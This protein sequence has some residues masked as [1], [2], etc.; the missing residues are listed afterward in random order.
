[1]AW[2]IGLLG[3]SKIARGAVIAPAKASAD[4]EVVE[5]GT[6]Y[7]NSNVPSGPFPTI[8]SFTANATSVAKGTPA[9]EAGLHPGDVIVAVDGQAATRITLP[10][11]RDGLRERATGS[12]VILGIKSDDKVRTVR[13]ILRDLL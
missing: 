12:V 11:M 13:L 4:F 1:M 5:M 7:T 8:N 9:A 3:A 6:I 10:A 2:R